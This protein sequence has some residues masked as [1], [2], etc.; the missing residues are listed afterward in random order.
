MTISINGNQYTYNYSQNRN[1]KEPNP[2]LSYGSN[3]IFDNYNS[4]TVQNVSTN[5]ISDTCA[6]GVDD[7]QIS[8]GEKASSFIKGIF[9]PITSLFKSPENFIK[10]AAMMIGGA[11]LCA[12]TGGAA[13]PFLVAA[14]VIGGGVQVVK[15]AINASNATTDAEAKAAWEDMGCGT[16]VV[17]GSVIG[18]KSAAKAAG[19]EGAE[20]M[21]ALQATKACFKYSGQKVG[22]LFTGS[23]SA[24]GAAT[25][26]SGTKTSSAKSNS[27]PAEVGATNKKPVVAESKP[28]TTETTVA[29]K[30]TTVE[31]KPATTETEAANVNNK[32]AKG[33][34][35]EG[36]SDIA[37]TKESMQTQLDELTQNIENL[38]QEANRIKSN[39]TSGEQIL[40]SSAKQVSTQI[41]HAQ[42]SPTS[43]SIEGQSKT[44][45][46]KAE[47]GIKE[48]IIEE[49][50][51]TPEKASAP[52][53]TTQHIKSKNA[54]YLANRNTARDIVK[55]NMEE[56]DKILL[57]KDGRIKYFGDNGPE[58]IRFDELVTPYEEELGTIYHGTTTEA[59]ASILE[60][61]FSEDFISGHGYKD[62]TGGTY[63]TRTK[64]NM[65]GDGVIEAKFTGKVGQVNT[66]TVNRIKCHLFNR[67]DVENY[68]SS[69]GKYSETSIS[70]EAIIQEY[71]RQK[72]GNMGFQGIMSTN[73]SSA[74][75]CKYF[76]ALD[77]SLIEIIH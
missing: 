77:P 23:S 40:D 45:E 24:A 8:F 52:T 7:G 53:T 36:K 60:N 17:A 46:V 73:Y 29:E 32:T 33:N 71:V 13:A 1:V 6:D 55:N 27:K 64:T 21:S 39:T 62:G 11:A 43:A 65:Y 10:G 51:Q 37:Q 41:E 38:K 57:D 14:G 12:V 20:N 3:S 48:T 2:T 68:A 42:G 63:F 5:D 66:E 16:G 74:A 59:K 58:S 26:T 22:G 69:L 47:S 35:T 28:T 61:G 31:S 9:S 50:I 76:A 30:P 75:N 44:L 15:G 49:K 19:I 70:G 34:I 72:I 4:T 67:T 18:A 54:E 25:S 56:L